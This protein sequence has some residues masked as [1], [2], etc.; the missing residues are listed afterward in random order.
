MRNHIYAAKALAI[1][2]AGLNDAFSELR[3]DSGWTD[4]F[5]DKSFNGGT[6]TVSVSGSL[7]DLT[8][9][10]DAVSS[11]SYAANVEADITVGTSSPYVIRIDDLRINE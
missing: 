5:T 3:S 6:Y 9:T 11:E 7:P 1:A 8:I 2:E 10:S 4:G